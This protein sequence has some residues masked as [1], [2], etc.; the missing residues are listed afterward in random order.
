M[1]KLV[2]ALGLICFAH[3]A[4]AQYCAEPV[5]STFNC[6]GPT[7]SPG[8]GFSFYF[9]PIFIRSTL[10]PN[11]KFLLLT[12][13]EKG[14][15]SA[16]QSIHYRFPDGAVFCRMENAFTKRYGFMFSIHAGGYSER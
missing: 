2:L 1:K 12:D 7:V 5:F 6:W 16:F 14:M 4:T 13:P 11:K 10:T 8:L 15:Y 9:Q 3:K